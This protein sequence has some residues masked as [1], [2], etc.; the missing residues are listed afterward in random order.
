MKT[1]MAYVSNIYIRLTPAIG[2]LYTRKFPKD[3]NLKE[4]VRNLVDSIRSSFIDILNDAT[5]MDANTKRAAVDK[6]KSTIAHIGF[7]KELSNQT[8]IREHYKS[9]T[10]NENEFFMNV[11]R[12]QKFN[13]D[14]SF[15]QLHKSNDEDNW[16]RYTMLAPIGASYVFQKNEIRE[17]D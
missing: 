16:L 14:Y 5:W 3:E 13:Q 11:L 10:L 2:A 15:R 17:F 12:V 9:L 6:A 1:D 7:L 8:K 4:K